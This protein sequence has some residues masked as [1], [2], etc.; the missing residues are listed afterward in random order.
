MEGE[1]KPI[2]IVDETRVDLLHGIG[3]AAELGAQVRNVHRLAVLIFA[4]ERDLVGLGLPGPRATKFEQSGD[5]A[6]PGVAD[7][8]DLIPRIDTI[9]FG[10]LF[11]NWRALLRPGIYSKNQEP[12][13]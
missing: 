8:L 6:V 3:L 2:V 5:F 1:Q 12:K 13:D 7:G 11:E 4:L 10:N 9:R